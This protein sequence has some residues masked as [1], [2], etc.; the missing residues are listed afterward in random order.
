MNLSSTGFMA[1]EW[2]THTAGWRTLMPLKH[3]P[4]GDMS[5]AAVLMFSYP[6]HVMSA[7]VE[8]QNKLTTSV[9]SQCETREPFRQLFTQLFDYPKFGTPFKQG[10]E[11]RGARASLWQCAEL[12]NTVH[13]LPHCSDRYYY[14]HNSGLQQQYVLYTQTALDAPAEVFIDPNTLSDDGTVSL[15]VGGGSG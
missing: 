8:A 9:L 7:V 10:G 12:I 3:R 14:Y 11:R 13:T 5:G 15:K 4:V 2:Q 1:S 6:P